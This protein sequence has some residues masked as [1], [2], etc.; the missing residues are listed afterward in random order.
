[1]QNKKQS[2]RKISRMLIAFVCCFPVMLVI[3]AL[4]KGANDFLVF[5]IDL[6]VGGTILFV[7]FIVGD[8]ADEKRERLH[9]DYLMEKKEREQ[10][11][12]LLREFDDITATNQEEEK[13]DSKEQS[14]D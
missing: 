7:T 8:R 12:N 5:M 13:Q 1:M 11:K 6:V 10:Q 2:Y 3:T 14:Q 9:Q 4:L